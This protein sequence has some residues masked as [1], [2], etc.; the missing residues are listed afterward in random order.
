MVLK[1]W[2]NKKF[3]VKELYSSYWWAG[4]LPIL[5]MSHICPEYDSGYITN[6]W[7]STAYGIQENSVSAAHLLNIYKFRSENLVLRCKTSRR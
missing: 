3:S 2:S 1:W 5:R 7:Y 6:Q 4:V